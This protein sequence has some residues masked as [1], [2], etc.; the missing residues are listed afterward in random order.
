MA[1]A[2]HER[3]SHYEV[4]GALG[5]GGMGEVYHALDL[6]LGRGVA[7]KLLPERLAADPEMLERFRR[8]ARAA[9]ALNDP[10]I[11]TVHDID[12][13]AGRWFIVMEL[14]EGQTL[15]QRL[16]EKPLPVEEVLEL[17]IQ[18]GN[19]LAAAHAKGIVHRDLKPANIFVTERGRAKV[20]DFGLAK[21]SRAPTQ[22]PEVGISA[23]PT[24]TGGPLTS[25][26]MAL[27]TV[28]YM[29]PE[30][31]LGDTLDARSD[32]FSLGVVLFEMATGRPP[33][34]GA[35]AAGVF[36]AILHGEPQPPSRV[37]E[38]LPSELTR[39]IMKLLE[40]ERELRYQTARDLVVDLTRLKRT[41]SMV[42]DWSRS[43]P[44]QT[45]IVVL[46]FDN[47]S[48]DPDNAFFADGLTDE[49]IAELSK[50]RALRVISRT[51]AMLLKG[52]K[53]SVPVIARE[54]D[55]G[56]ALEG[57][58]RKAGNNV[59]IT[60]QLIDATSDSHVWA[61]RYSGTLDDIFDLQEKMA[62]RIV[63]ALRVRLTP[64]EERRIGSPPTS[65]PR[66][67]EVYLRA[68]HETSVFTRQGVERARQLI[69]E[70]LSI[71]GDDPLLYGALAYY[72]WA[73]YDCGFS[74][75]EETL[76]QAEECAAKSLAL[77]PNLSHAWLAMGLV[78]YK[79]GD[80]QEWVRHAKRAVD[81][82]RNIDALWMLAFVLAE[83]GRS[84]EAYVYGDEG[85]AR[86]PLTFI[87]ALGRA[88]VDLFEGK[89]DDA[90]NRIRDSAARLA[91]G[92]P[93]SGCWLG[94]AAMYAG[95][96]DEARSVLGAVAAMNVVPWSDFAKLGVGALARDRR[97]VR[98]V[99]ANSTLR[100]IARTDEY[101]PT[102]LATCL[103]CVGEADEALDWIEH[104]ISWGFSNHRFLEH[105]NH[106]LE[107]LRGDARFQT[108]LGRAR[109]RERAFEV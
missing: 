27:G 43:G 107:P 12:E 46:P 97:A 102:F 28:A 6:K 39:V 77:N 32:L 83:V 103:S 49:L 55:V 93:F 95:R 79:R 26:G 101:Y 21:V 96:D 14:L 47:L 98:D 94:K 84:K 59:R 9:S 25:P 23:S 64:E 15:A 1:L 8:E 104:A 36:D 69:T 37:R 13:D 20:L 65:D 51:S 31:A 100:S 53:K 44:E 105:H 63:D 81:L 10:G 70:A 45:A 56:Y 48:P 7:L 62:R 17:S 19:A 88:V 4:L 67:Y 91:S 86:D 61:E 82:D 22:G 60:A 71:V 89:F 74:H 5:V 108:L 80:M 92:E 78:R 30:Q 72:C 66:A 90:V 85:T 73:A 38:D 29:S 109:D 106:F 11:C 99:L 2:P 35:T 16:A 57:T 87:T 3:I 52:V 33:F 50:V 54:L 40:K 41:Q 24:L 34:S 76:M 75:E 58:V 18:L 42:P 68:R